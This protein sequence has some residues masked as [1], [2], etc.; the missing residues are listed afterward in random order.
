MKD[1]KDLRARRVRRVR[2]VKRV[3]KAT[4]EHRDRRD[5][6]DRRDSKDQ[7]VLWDHKD[8]PAQPALKDHKACRDLPDRRVLPVTE[9]LIRLWWRRCVGIKSHARM[10]STR[11]ALLHWLLAQQRLLLMAPISGLLT[12]IQTTSRGCVLRTV[13]SWELT[14]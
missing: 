1:H 2:K 13:L 3:I 12:T 8:Q 10:E 6:P 11:W 9:P 5:L 7:W 4:P 14:R